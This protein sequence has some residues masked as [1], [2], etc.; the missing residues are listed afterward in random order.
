MHINEIGGMAIP[1]HLVSS[2]NVESK[3]VSLRFLGQRLSY[4]LFI[5]ATEEML[6]SENVRC[7]NCMLSSFLIGCLIDLKDLEKNVQTKNCQL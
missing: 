3:S 6:F 7:V 2:V 4:L 5:S 1:R